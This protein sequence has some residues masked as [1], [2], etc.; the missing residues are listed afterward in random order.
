MVY[1]FAAM[2]GWCV[3]AGWGDGYGG[4]VRHVM[5][6][7]ET[8]SARDNAAI[9]AIG[10]FTWEDGE[11]QVPGEVD[12]GKQGFF[13]AVDLKSSA[14]VGLDVDP[15]TVLWW[16][17]QRDDVRALLDGGVNLTSA[18]HQ[19]S[20]WLPRD[21]KVWGNGSMFDNTILKSAYRAV[22]ARCPISYRDDL[23]FRTMRYLFPHVKDVEYGLK[24][25]ALHDAIRQGLHLQRMLDQFRLGSGEAA[26]AQVEGA[27]L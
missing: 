20:S 7:L 17:K 26:N 8:M 4:P 5:L 27:D 12:E 10:A 18:L 14:G 19:F 23:D 11:V 3:E 22:G 6:D 1:E 9:V 15:E 2:G 21:A 24:H 16:A 13:C 25:H